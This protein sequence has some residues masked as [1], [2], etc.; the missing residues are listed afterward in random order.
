MRTQLV[1]D[2][3]LTALPRRQTD[4]AVVIRCQDAGDAKAP[5]NGLD[6]LQVS[7]LHADAVFLLL[8]LTLAL[9]TVTRPRI[10]AH[11]VL[12][13]PAA[14]LLVVELLERAGQERHAAANPRMPPQMLT[15]A[16]RRPQRQLSSR[17][18]GCSGSIRSLAAR[19]L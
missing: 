7:Q 11:R 3:S 10:S 13:R 19:Q 6:P 4:G 5:R 12:A 9:V 8:G 15:R 14:V 2:K 17:Q 18:A 1:I 16:P